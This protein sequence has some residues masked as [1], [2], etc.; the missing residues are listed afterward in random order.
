MVGADKLDPPK[1][2]IPLMLAL[3]R[4][5]EIGEIQRMFATC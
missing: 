1:A 2:R 5:A 3:T 4:I